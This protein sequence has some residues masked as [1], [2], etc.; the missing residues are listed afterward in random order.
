MA[1][2]NK[3]NYNYRP[4]KSI[5]R[6]IFL[7]L[8]KEIY[9]VSNS[10][11][12]TYIGFG[13]IF[14]IDFKLIHKELGVFKMIN[15]ESNEIDKKRF[16]YNK[17]FSNIE[18]MWGKSTDVLP[19][20]DWSGKKIIWLDY[21]QSLQSYMFEDMETVFHSL[22]EGSFFFTSCNS[23]M[24]RYFNSKLGLH[25]E[26]KFRA[27]FSR[28]SPFH[29]NSAMMTNANSPFLVRTMFL[30]TINS[31]LGNRNLAIPDSNMHFV[32]LQLVFIV[33]KD[34]AP[35][36]SIGGVLLRRSQLKKF[37]KSSF[38]GLPYIRTSES[39]LD[40]ES[41]I[42][43]NSEIDLINRHLPEKKVR[44]MKKEELKFLPPEEIEKYHSFYRY[45]PSFVEIREF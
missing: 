9:G 17:P 15:I 31:I 36:V 38:L 34:G 10:S 44:F 21:D 43:T 8:L 33:Y 27:E 4:S 25:D 16:E 24:T 2:Y 22:E 42:L 23:L 37:S 28:Y 19:L 20:I 35:M 41:P 5:E 26:V 30:S 29:L 12:L 40:I 7:E 32:F 3:F 39:Y 45:N 18:L 14:Y 11:K 1:S 13:S 6:K